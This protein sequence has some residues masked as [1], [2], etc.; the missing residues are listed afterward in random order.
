M[1]DE[2]SMALTIRE[3]IGSLWL[4]TYGCRYIRPIMRGLFYCFH[5]AISEGCTNL[6]CGTLAKT[7]G[8]R[9]IGVCAAFLR[10]NLHQTKVIPHS[11]DEIVQTIKH[12]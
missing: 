9:Q 12:E 3:H 2:A 1:V 6:Y 11:L 4:V 5:R 10:I 8:V 7:H